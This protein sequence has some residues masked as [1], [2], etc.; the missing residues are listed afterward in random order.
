MQPTV[1]DVVHTQ[2]LH[3]QPQ[4]PES[5][6]MFE[7]SCSSRNVENGLED[8]FDGGMR[9]ESL[10]RVQGVDVESPAIRARR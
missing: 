6:F 9:L 8:P 10:E 2:G 1:V 7:I 5:E 3:P 4:E